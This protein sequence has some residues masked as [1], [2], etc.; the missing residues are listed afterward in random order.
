MNPNRKRLLSDDTPQRGPREGLVPN[1]KAT[2]RE[3]LHEVMRFLHYSRRTEHTYWQWIER[4]LRHFRDPTRPGP[5]GWRHPRELGAT[6]VGEFLAHLATH[7]NVAAGTQNQALNALVFL[8]SRVLHQ[9]LGELG[10]WL[11]A[12][13]RQ[14]LP[15]VLTRAEVTALFEAAEPE[16]RLP[17]Q[18]L[19]G[20]GLRL[21]ELLRLRVKDLNLS[22]NLLIVR[23]GKGGKDRRTM[24]PEVLGEPLRGH[25]EQVRRQ[26]TA[27]L[28]AGFAGVWLPDALAR[29]YPAA[30]KEWAWQW[31][32]PAGGLVRWR[33]EGGEEGWWRHHLAPEILQRAMKAAV[34]KAKIAKP[35]TPHTLRHSF[36]THLLESGVDI[37]TVQDLLGHQDVATTQIYTH[38]MQK[39]GVGVRSPL[40]R[41]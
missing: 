16:M 4:F 35:A 11:R 20:A 7:A 36:A 31:V 8:Y 25:L 28:A 39:P 34:R 12:E 30:P 24:I 13:R 18:L 6:Q 14:R 21:F 10:D 3:Q 26:H 27:D 17:L 19:Y 22:Q 29:K 1:P 32:F 40:D 9:P 5:S 15:V 38:V 41:D 37:R 33:P 2:L 23:E